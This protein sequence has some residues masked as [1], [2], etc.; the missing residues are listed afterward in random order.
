M[1]LKEIKQTIGKGEFAQALDRLKEVVPEPFENTYLTISA[2]FYT[3]EKNQMLGLN[4]PIEQQNQIIYNLLEFISEIELHEAKGIKREMLQ[5]HKRYER[6]L[7]VAYELIQEIKYGTDPFDIEK[8]V[9][10]YSPNS[11]RLHPKLSD[12]S[13]SREELAKVLI[14]D[15]R[16]Y[17]NLYRIMT[18]NVLFWILTIVI[19]PILLSQSSLIEQFIHDASADVEGSD[20]EEN[21]EVDVD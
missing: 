3:W 13:F 9:R 4:P 7:G 15:T 11:H 21:L 19:A 14:K 5:T 8:L 10:K 16:T 1:S 20:S 12:T 17:R 6:D 2:R 18:I